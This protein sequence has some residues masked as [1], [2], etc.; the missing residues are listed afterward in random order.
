M[1]LTYPL[2]GQVGHTRGNLEGHFEHGL[3]SVREVYLWIPV[4]PHEMEQITMIGELSHHSDGPAC[5]GKDRH[6]FY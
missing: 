6:V 2:F 4:P 1:V 3:S 5:I